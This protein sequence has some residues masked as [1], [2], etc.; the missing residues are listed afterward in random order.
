MHF[1]DANQ[2]LETFY[3]LRRAGS[4]STLESSTLLYVL[5]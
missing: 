3:P 4:G 2:M 1:K 5:L